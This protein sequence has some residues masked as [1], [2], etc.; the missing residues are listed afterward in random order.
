[1]PY[2][3][4]NCFRQKPTGGV[5]PFCGYDDSNAV[6]DFPLA[7]KQGAILNG[8]YTVGRV[9]GQGGFGI[10]YIAQDYQSGE[11]VAIKE[12]L[13]SEFAGREPENNSV[14]VHSSIQREN[15]EYGKAQFLEEA[16]TLAAFNG[17]EHIVRIHSY[18]EENN[19]AYFVM[20][21]V[22][23]AA[24][25]K[26]LA[27]KGGRLSVEEANRLLLPLMESL[28]KIHAKGIIHR[29][30]APDNIII[31]K[32][33]SAKLIDFG[34]ARY[35]TGEKSKSLDV[36]LK[37]GFAPTEQYMRRGRQG[38]FTDVYALAATYYYAITGKVLP[39]AVERM[40]E[41][42]MF[43][44]S[45]LGVKISPEQEDVLLK[46]LEVN[47]GDRYQNMAEFHR[48]MAAASPHPQE[49]YSEIEQTVRA[50]KAEAELLEQKARE[51]REKVTRLE[52]EKAGKTEGQKPENNN[53]QKEYP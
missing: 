31:T 2:I 29:D 28:G 27:Q 16:R 47:A 7:L 6:K 40:Q 24:L 10:T 43:V 36:V 50:A 23:G 13:P 45:A 48:E 51:A 15:Y 49:E 26:Y 20:E 25:D 53:E 38:P 9:L 5:C 18:F 11:R 35:S 4:Y 37:H 14:R 44:P 1:M 52:Q 12:Y 22:D 39:D 30:I 33:G 41:D 34:A 46:A 19:T 32:D 17:D 42:T 3:C 8:R 21:Y